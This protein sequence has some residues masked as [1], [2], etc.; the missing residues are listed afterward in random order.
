MFARI[1]LGSDLFL[2]KWELDLNQKSR[3]Q[4]DKGELY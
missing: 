4:K 2:N 1:T 3:I